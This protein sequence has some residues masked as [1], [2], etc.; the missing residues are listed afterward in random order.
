MFCLRFDWA[1][2]AKFTNICTIGMIYMK[3]NKAECGG[4]NFA[5]IPLLS[6]PCNWGL[7]APSTSAEFSKLT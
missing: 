2:F 4:N 3:N 1:Y 5:V 7:N 6:G